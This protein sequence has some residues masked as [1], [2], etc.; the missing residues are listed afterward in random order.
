MKKTTELRL[1]VQ[2]VQR[3]LLHVTLSLT[4]FEIQEH[5]IW[6]PYALIIMDR[7]LLGLYLNFNASQK[8]SILLQVLLVTTAEQNTK[9]AGICCSSL[10]GLGLNSE[11][12]C[13][14][15]W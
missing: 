14:P 4:P 15:L 8:P 13:F 3:C 2:L 9:L 1:E 11:S 7:Q 12:F 6:Q 10:P 5:N